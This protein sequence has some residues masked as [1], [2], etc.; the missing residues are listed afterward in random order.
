M[1]ILIVGSIAVPAERRNAL[2][3]AIRPLV[4][5]T[6]AEE[7][8][9]LEYA[10]SADTVDEGRIVVVE[11]WADEASLAAHFEHQNFLDTKDAL[12]ANGSGASAIRKYRVDLDE[13]VRDGDNRYR[14]DFFTDGASG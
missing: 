8:G 14:A 5:R 1:Q 6:R 12:H 9:C 13:P 2:L 11:H 3:A 10:F 7:P 4:S